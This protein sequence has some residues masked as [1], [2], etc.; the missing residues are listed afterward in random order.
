MEKFDLSSSYQLRLEDKFGL[1]DFTTLQKVSRFDRE[2]AELS[3][4]QPTS[5]QLSSSGAAASL[6]T[7]ILVAHVNPFQKGV[8]F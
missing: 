2:L 1:F 3:R 7:M 5:L 4:R 6:T 8:S